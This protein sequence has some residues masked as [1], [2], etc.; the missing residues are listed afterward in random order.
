MTSKRISLLLVMLAV[1]VGWSQDGSSGESNSAA[2]DAESHKAIKAQFES[3][4]EAFNNHDAAAV[5]RCWTANGVSIAEETG[6]RTEGRDDLVR[7]FESFFAEQPDTRLSGTIDRVRT[8]APNVATI[9]G[10]TVLFVTDEEPIES[11]FTAILVKEND[12]WLISSSRERSVP[13]PPSPYDALK[14]F[15]W[16]VGSWQDQTGDEVTVQTTVRWSANQA[17]LIRS[18]KVEH[19]AGDALEGTEVIGWDPISKQIRTWTFNSDGSFGQGTASKHEDELVLK[20]WQIVGAGQV[21]AATKIISRIDDD[22]MTVR[23]IGETLNG[24]P[25]PSSDPVTVIRVDNP[26]TALSAP[27]EPVVR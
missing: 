6:E 10:R 15:E 5:G 2:R 17:F 21:A 18:Y 20:M 9:D 12:K 1:Q 23:T 11:A 24:E 3:Y 14:E 4:A 16:L 7:E 13:V 19:S 26:E 8:V 22:K 25:V 27:G